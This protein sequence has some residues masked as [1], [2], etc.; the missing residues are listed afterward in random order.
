HENESTNLGCFTYQ[1]IQQLTTSLRSK[2]YREAKSVHERLATISLPLHFQ[3]YYQLKRESLCPEKISEYDQF[4]IEALSLS[5]NVLNS[6]DQVEKRLFLN[7]FSRLVSY[8]DNTLGA[9][10]Q[11]AFTILKM[12]K[13]AYKEL[14]YAGILY[15]HRGGSGSRITHE[16]RF[17]SV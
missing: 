7:R 13:S 12:F 8:K 1:E 6:A 15:E 17:Q 10:K 4:A 11:K 2:P 3:Y 14:L 5:N 9:E 16:I